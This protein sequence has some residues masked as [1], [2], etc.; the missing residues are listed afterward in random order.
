MILLALLFSSCQ[1]EEKK[2]EVI[3]AEV[4]ETILTENEMKELLGSKS[5]Q[6]KHRE[7]FIRHWV[8]TELLAQRSKEL[9]L[10][11][12]ENYYGIL[13]RSRKELAAS[14][15]LQSY[16]VNQHVTA[17]ER[18]LKNYFR[19]NKDDYILLE[20]AFVINLAAFNS[21]SSAI[22]FR[23]SVLKQGWNSTVDLFSNDS[24][25][26][27]L[28]IESTLKRSQH[29]SKL[30][31]RALDKLFRGEVTLVLKT[32]LNDFVI[33]Q[34]IDKIPKNSIPRFKYI[35]DNIEKSYQYF[36]KKEI[37]RNYIDSLMSEKNIK[38]Y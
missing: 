31:A 33:V 23:N 35:K 5:N 25:L 36:K 13:D 17:D 4:N 27:D 18:T 38:I 8:E 16:L 21:E 1:K 6:A 37:A 15:A 7:E 28:K 9:N 19:K 3:L 11:S 24:A 26:L 10:L 20:D 22:K 30:V 14:I 12:D 34:L 32:E 29:K 2:D